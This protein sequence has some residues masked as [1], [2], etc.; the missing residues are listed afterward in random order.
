M[1]LSEFEQSPDYESIF[2]DDCIIEIGSDNATIV[3]YEKL[4]RIEKGQIDKKK[5][6]KLIKLEVRLTQQTLQRMS[7]ASLGLLNAKRHALELKGKA[8]NNDPSTERAW[9]EY[10]QTINSA[11]YDTENIKLNQIDFDKLG[12]ALENFAARINQPVKKRK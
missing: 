6:H 2:A 4:T 9:Y 1:I 7:F 5:K 11:R 8:K 3:F 12:N 10:D